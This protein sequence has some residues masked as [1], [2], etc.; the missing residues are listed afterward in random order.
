MR[1][2]QKKFIAEN[3]SKHVKNNKLTYCQEE[4]NIN[5]G[6]YEFEDAYKG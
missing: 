2:Q 5:S 4:R 6:R 1:K 3:P